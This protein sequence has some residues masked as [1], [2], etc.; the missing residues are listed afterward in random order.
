MPVGLDGRFDAQ[1]SDFAGQHVKDADREIIRHLKETGALYEQ[2]VI[3]H[4]YPFCYRSETPLIYRAVPSWYVKVEQL[5]DRLRRPTAKCA[6]CPII[7][8]R[9][10]SASGWTGLGIGRSPGT[11]FGVRR[12]PFG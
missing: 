3:V 2:D 5:K 4:S 6:G 11:G 10:A 1:V 7:F 9:G 12:C 8:R